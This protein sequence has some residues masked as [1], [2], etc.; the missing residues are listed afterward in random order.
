[1]GF[2]S[3]HLNPTTISLS[4]SRF[5]A[6]HLM[7]IGFQCPLQNPLLQSACTTE[8]EWRGFHR[9]PSGKSISLP[10][11]F[12]CKEEEGMWVQRSRTLFPSQC[13]SLKKPT[14]VYGGK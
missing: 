3:N 7:T 10:K 5:P 11:H 8:L 12:R 1:M 14:F 13:L 4:G 6:E 9:M 2:P